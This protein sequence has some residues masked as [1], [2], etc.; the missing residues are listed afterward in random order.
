MKSITLLKGIINFFFLGF[1]IASLI[2]VYLTV[3]IPGG[4]LDSL[5]SFLASSNIMGGRPLDYLSPNIL[6]V[7][8]M[9]R[10]ALF[11]FILFHFRFSVLK[12]RVDNIYG[13]DVRRHLDYMGYGC[14]IFAAIQI[15]L[16]TIVPIL[17]NKG[18]NIF[19]L[20]FTAFNS[21]YFIIALGLLFIYFSKVLEQAAILKSENDLTI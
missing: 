19:P 15:C 7:I 8:N 16:R 18:Y 4:S 11:F 3:F 10:V 17:Y 21:A 14:I 13:A 12:F 9:T 5:W 20:N 1:I 6:L 2:I